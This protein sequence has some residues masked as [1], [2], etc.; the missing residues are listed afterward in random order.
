MT[1]ID[2]SSVDIAT[3]NSMDGFALEAELILYWWFI[4]Q[5][6]RNT[7]YWDYVPCFWKFQWGFCTL[8]IKEKITWEFR[9]PIFNEC[10]LHLLSFIF[11]IIQSRFVQ[12]ISIPHTQRNAMSW[13]CFDFDG[14]TSAHLKVSPQTNGMKVKWKCRYTFLTS[15]ELQFSHLCVYLK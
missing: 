6:S 1:N 9:I 11:N 8:K 10:Y 15:L 5:I 13:E 7:Q 2:L 4:T 12:F 3:T 14:P